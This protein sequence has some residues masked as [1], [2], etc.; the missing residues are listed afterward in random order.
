MNP[1]FLFEPT[2]HREAV[3]FIRNKPVLQ[4]K[5]FK[6]LLP[7]LKARAFTISGV[8]SL[9]VLQT[10]RDRLA[11]L[12]TGGDWNTIK[13]EIARDISPWLIDP[14][15]DEETQVK[16]AVAADAKA[17]LLLRTHG[18]QA[19]AA[20]SY[21]V[22]ERQKDALPY[23][24]YFTMGDASVR[25]EHAAL[26]GIC[27]P[28]DSP[29]WAEHFPPW[30]WGCRCQAVPITREEYEEIKA[31]DEQHPA[32]QRNALDGP[33]RKQVEQS[34]RLVRGPNNIVDLRTPS[35]RGSTYK[36]EPRS[37]TL[38]TQQLRGRYDAD[39]WQQFETWSR[40][41]DV[42]GVPL[43]DWVNG[44]QAKTPADRV[45]QNPVSNAFMLNTK[46]KAAR[47]LQ[48]SMAVIDQVHDD[49]ELPRI[50]LDDKAGRGAN[51]VFIHTRGGEPLRIGIR[52]NSPHPEL[53]FAHEVGHFIDH[54]VLGIR[55]AFASDQHPTLQA[56]FDAVSKSDAYKNLGE[57]GL[58]KQHR[59]YYLSRRE[60]W[61]RSY[62][63]YIAEKSG[64]A[65][66]LD[67]LKKITGGNSLP[68]RQ[69]TT[70]D[71]APIKK[72]MDE[73]LQS[74]GWLP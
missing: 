17:E 58:K 62:A 24:Q 59:E 46:G 16:Q 30:D 6:N 2:P 29:F 53:T 1:D 74:K 21:Q 43:F 35:Q 10:V 41:V 19:Y 67:G 7:E 5:V 72:A 28:A 69:W 42:D 47:M 27:L 18:G 26:E 60:L 48:D 63:Q 4:Q 33:A 12:P 71:F 70:E 39:V 51:G 25:E 36:F 57:S 22:M 65:A 54:Q 11:G 73:L 14:K 38:T 66:M 9:N 64:N 44:A 32:D 23:W 20:A 8:E 31:D 45:P 61:A 15:A 50:I 56:W 55:G 52:A 49:G 40:Q 13:H 3:D 37:L 34:N 68:Y